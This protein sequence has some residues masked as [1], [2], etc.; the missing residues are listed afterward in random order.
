[1]TNREHLRHDDSPEAL[2]ILTAV[3]GGRTLPGVEPTD[4]GA[5]VDWDRLA[6]SWL[7]STERAAVIIARG[8]A[9]AE[10]HG[11]LPPRVA[12]VVATATAVRLSPPF[13]RHSSVGAADAASPNIGVDR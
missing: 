3:A 1:V 11:G 6:S 13:G 4:A 5:F 9:Q 10:R 8:V 2:A 12:A 7:S